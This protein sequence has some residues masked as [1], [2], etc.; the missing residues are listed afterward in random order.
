[1][2]TPI[3]LTIGFRAWFLTLLI[4]G[5]LL[6]TAWG[7]T[8]LAAAEGIHQ[9]TLLAVTAD[10]R[11]HAHEMI[12][13]LGVALLGGFLLTAVQNWTGLRPLRPSWLLLSIL[14]WISARISLI[15]GGMEQWSGYLLSAASVLMVGLAITRVIM[16]RR[17][18]H[19]LIFP[20]NLVFLA[21]LDLLFRLHIDQPDLSGGIAM[22]GLWPLL[23]ILLF[24]S[25][26]ILPAFTAGRSGRRSGSLGRIGAILLATGPLLLMLLSLLPAGLARSI[27]MGLI[28]LVLLLTGLL[29]L[30][31]WWQPD[32][33]REPMLLILYAGFGMSL[34]ALPLLAGYWLLPATLTGPLWLDAG[35]HALGLGVLGV[36]GPGMVLRVSAGHT[37]RPIAMPKL[38]RV[39]F[40]MAA[41]LWLL[42]IGTP[43]TGYHGW[44]LAMIA[45][46]MALSYLAV[47]RHIGP[48]LI[49]PRADGR[50]G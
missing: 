7:W 33:L 8:W 40:M 39:V 35:I 45:G 50:R 13:G 34:T 6:F 46:G 25:Q 20:L 38:L 5:S 31:R 9:P 17:Q 19:N 16:V 23:S 22:A 14:L 44:L 21:S 30:Y 28:A 3:L 26:R 32:V 37:G 49:T 11:W 36:I 24:I 42:R 4:S 2:T 1:M 10:W 12:F 15:L 48:W 29:G 43:I 27:V 47:L 18:W 41:V